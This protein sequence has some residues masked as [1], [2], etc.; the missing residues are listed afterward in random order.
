[1]AAV[2]ALIGFAVQCLLAIVEGASLERAMLFALMHWLLW[3]CAGLLAG[4][5]ACRVVRDI[6]A[7][8][9]RRL[10]DVEREAF[11]RRL[12]AIGGQPTSSAT[13]SVD[14]STSPHRPER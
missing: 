8:R 11:A 12:A 6:V 2:W 14:T 3:G 9:V 1:V 5:V 7:A 13:K 4:W 10:E